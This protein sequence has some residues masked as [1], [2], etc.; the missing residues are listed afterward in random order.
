MSKEIEKNNAL[1]IGKQ[2]FGSNKKMTVDFSPEIM[3]KK[4]EHF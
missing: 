1:L 2:S 3:E 4:M